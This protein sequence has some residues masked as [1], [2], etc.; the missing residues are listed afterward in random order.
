MATEKPSTN[1]PERKEPTEPSTSQPEVA[2]EPQRLLNLLDQERALSSRLMRIILKERYTVLRLYD[3]L[4][5]KLEGNPSRLPPE[6]TETNEN[7]V[8]PSC[9]CDLEFSE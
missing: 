9:R 7:N 6:A 8:C 2:E 4:S 1:Q 5:K 3:A